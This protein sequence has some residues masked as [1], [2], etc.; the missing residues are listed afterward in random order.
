MV[1][2]L[3]TAEFLFVLL[4]GHLFFCSFCFLFLSEVRQV[5][6]TCSNILQW[7]NPYWAQVYFLLCISVLASS[8]LY[9]GIDITSVTG[10]CLGD[11]EFTDALTGS[12]P[13]LLSLII[14]VG[15]RLAFILCLIIF[16]PH[17]FFPKIHQ[18]LIRLCISM[19]V[20]ICSNCVIL[21]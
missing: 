8:Y 10:A 12:G 5:F 13:P 1:G 6:R 11:F 20:C 18:S 17:C 16:F 14:M 4:D 3:S 15:C 9:A 19:Y 21:I 2:I 7:G